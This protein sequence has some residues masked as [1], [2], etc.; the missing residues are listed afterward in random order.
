MLIT[1]L[2]WLLFGALVGWVAGI[3]M[4][5]HNSSL[6]RDIILGIVGSIVGGYV[7]SLLGFGNLGGDFNFDLVNI[8]IAIGGACIVIF[9]AGLFRRR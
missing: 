2:L 6:L 8:G 9:V 4:N 1:I 5:T 7:A 3:I